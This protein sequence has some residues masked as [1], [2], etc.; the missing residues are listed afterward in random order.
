MKN[1]LNMLV[2]ATLGLTAYALL[3]FVPAGTFDYWR[4][5]MLLAVIVIPSWIASI[6]FLRTN[7]AA[8]QRRKLGVEKRAAQ[9]LIAYSV[10]AL[11]AA[12]IVVSVLDHRFGWSTVPTVISLVGAVLVALG[13]GL[14]ALVIAQNSHA[15][16]TVRVEEDQA[17]VST[18]LYGVVRHPM[19][20]SDT[21]LLV[22]VPLTLGSYWGL[23]FLVPV[24]LAF[25]MRVL[26]EERMLQQE[27]A[28]YRDY[29]T[30]V[31]YRLVP[32]VW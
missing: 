21:C 7:P 28:G 13:N 27:L 24:F 2:S 17:L 26:D 20:T 32:G 5:W 14:I 31:R 15:A 10:M 30:K 9:K 12:M 23:I 18:G 11:W 3:V 19:Y 22:G 16:V 29:M 6:Y 1:I 4:G 25:A 8:L